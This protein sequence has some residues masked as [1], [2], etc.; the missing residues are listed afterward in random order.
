[1]PCTP[2][3]VS[4]FNPFRGKFASA[5]GLW[6]N[7]HRGICRGVHVYHANERA[8]EPEPVLPSPTEAKAPALAVVAHPR[9]GAGRGEGTRWSLEEALQWRDSTLASRV[10]DLSPPSPPP[11]PPKRRRRPKPA[12]QLPLFARQRCAE[13]SMLPGS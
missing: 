10:R 5:C 13:R 9:A 3:P 12:D 4:L 1:M 7:A 8:Q 11:A 2:V 6:V